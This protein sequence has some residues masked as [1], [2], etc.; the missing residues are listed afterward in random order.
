M[1]NKIKTKDEVRKIFYIECPECKKEIKGTS[2]SQ[3]EYNLKL[4]LNTHTKEETKK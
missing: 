3:V 4:H 1:K 2:Q